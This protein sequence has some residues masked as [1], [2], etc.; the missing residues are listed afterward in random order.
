MEGLAMFEWN[1]VLSVVQLALVGFSAYLLLLGKKAVETGTE[2]A[3]EKIAEA[4]VK[5][6]EWPAELARELQKTRGVERQELRFKSYGLLWKELRP[7]A[8]YS[9]EA[10]DA[11]RARKLAAALSSWY[12]SECGGL[13]L[14]THVRS[15]YFALQDL[16]HVASSTPGW[17]AERSADE[18]KPLFRK[19]LEAKSPVALDVFNYFERADF[20]TWAKVS[21]DHGKAWRSG[22]REVAASWG[23]LKAA[24][25]FAVL[26]QVGSILRTSMTND[27]ESRLP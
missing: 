1:I 12:F 23:G 2:T 3:A 8:L 4:V 13:M 10:L 20:Q 14:T 11:E 6:V 19:V 16:L 22:V 26:Q 21:A 17:L 7:L 25:H 9:G 27:V 5:K 24:E 18:P 15:Y